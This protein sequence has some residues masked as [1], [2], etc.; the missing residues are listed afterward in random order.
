MA[1]P[2]I[3][4]LAGR[5]ISV[6]GELVAA[7]APAAGITYQPTEDKMFYEVIRVVRGIPLFW[8]DHMD[9]L[10]R[11]VKD[12]MIVPSTLYQESV[13]LI[14]ANELSAANL[15]IVL[16]KNLRALH[17]TP[18][19]YPDESQIQQGVP[20]GLLSW[21][22]EDPN[23]KVIRSDY[24]KAVAE[25]FAQPGPF[26]SFFELLLADQAGYLTEG[27]RSNLFFLLGNEVLTAPDSKI[28]IGITRKYVQQSIDKAGLSLTTRMLTLDDVRAMRS[29]GTAIA[30][31]L[32]G[33]PIDLMPIRAIEDIE[34]DSA[35]DLS[36]RKL[37]DAYM[38]IVNSY[39]DNRK[40]LIA[41]YPHGDPY[42]DHAV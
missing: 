9:R 12:E 25:R 19:Y 22:R 15:R 27:S 14:A 2:I 1:Y 16:T 13:S 23:V 40:S 37:R 21:E 10:I 11:S 41:D 5:M 6:N 29:A 35:A 26:G 28:L 30:A 4:A 3:D 38:A 34:L 42:G 8:E 20:T 31:F 39:I 36:F 7:S 33:S 18:S 32:S 24:K 17:L